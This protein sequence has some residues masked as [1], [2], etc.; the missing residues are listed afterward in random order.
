MGL[1]IGYYYLKGHLFKPILIVGK[2]KGKVVPV[3]N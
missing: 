2:G 3:L 1:L